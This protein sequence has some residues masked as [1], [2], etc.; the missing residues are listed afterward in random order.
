MDSGAVLLNVSRLGNECTSNDYDNSALDL[1]PK[2]TTLNGTL[3]TALPIYTEVSGN[4]RQNGYR[5]FESIDLAWKNLTYKI[6]SG[7]TSK[8]LVENMSGEV[9]S[10]TLTAVMGPSGAGKTTLLNL[11][12][13][14]YDKGYTGEVHINGYVRERELFNKQSCYVMQEDRLLPVL[15][16]FEAISM[17]VELRMPNIEPR[18]KA[19]KVEQSIHEWGLEECR[20][21]YH[22]EP[23]RRPTET[24][25]HRPR[26]GQQPAGAFPRR[27]HQWPGQRV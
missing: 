22:G 11:L 18:D 24:A 7:K 10:G 19:K 1:E 3:G 26:A 5:N 25:G 6:K 21:T 8:I 12:T 2:A 27:T 23:L 15:T 14:F 4:S 20:N 17:S 16:A 13:G 9:R